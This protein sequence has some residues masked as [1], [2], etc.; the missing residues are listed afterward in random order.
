MQACHARLLAMHTR[1]GLQRLLS[2]HRFVPIFSSPATPLLPYLKCGSY[3]TASDKAHDLALNPG[4]VSMKDLESTLGPLSTTPTVSFMPAFCSRD[5][6]VQCPNCASV[7]F[8]ALMTPQVPPPSPLVVVISGP[9][10][11]GKDAVI[12][13]LQE[14][15]PD[16][17]FV[18]TATSR[19]VSNNHHLRAGL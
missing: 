8:D 4:V 13:R 6:P 16:L 17:Y 7:T 11:V 10:G 18:V 5:G 3:A 1:L 15:R 12:R 19:F 14:K 9:S 2:T